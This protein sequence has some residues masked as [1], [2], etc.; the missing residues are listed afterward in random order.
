MA[1]IKKFN[2]HSMKAEDVIKALDSSRENGLTEEE[3][4]VRIEKYGKNELIKQKGKTAFQIFIGQ[5]KDFLIYLLYFAIALMLLLL[6][7][8]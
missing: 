6:L 8:L 1:E 4:V 3:V 7:L 2:A 5:F